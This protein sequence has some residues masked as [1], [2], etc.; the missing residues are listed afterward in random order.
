MLLLLSAWHW[1]KVITVFYSC[2]DVEVYGPFKPAERGEA[3]G[4]SQ[5][6]L[7]HLADRNGSAGFTES[8]IF[9]QGMLWPSVSAYFIAFFKLSSMFFF[10]FFVSWNVLDPSCVR[11]RG[12]IINC[13]IIYFRGSQNIYPRLQRYSRGCTSWK[14]N[15]NFRTVSTRK[16]ISIIIFLLSQLLYP[17]FIHACL[18]MN[19]VNMIV[20]GI[21]REQNR[22]QKEGKIRR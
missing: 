16:D 2:L 17:L 4:L 3:E 7:N 10:F 20:V 14:M 11:H 19:G 13:F 21:K 22:F 18:S 5:E 6:V 15:D 12:S 9:T 8:Q 1:W